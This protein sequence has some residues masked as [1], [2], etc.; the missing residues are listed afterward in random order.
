[1]NKEVAT[2]EELDD[3]TAKW[4]AENPEAV[5]GILKNGSPDWYKKAEF[6]PHAEAERYARTLPDK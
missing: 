6:E 4:L 3:I 5:P 2:K 1:M